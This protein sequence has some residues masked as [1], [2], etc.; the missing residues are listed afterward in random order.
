[1]TFVIPGQNGSISFV[2]CCRQSK[3]VAFIIQTRRQIS[4]IWRCD[5]KVPTSLNRTDLASDL[6]RNFYKRCLPHAGAPFRISDCDSFSLVC[7]QS[8][9]YKNY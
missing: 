2:T 9:Y 1:M 5:L 8:Q 7:L 3:L 4:P 6:K